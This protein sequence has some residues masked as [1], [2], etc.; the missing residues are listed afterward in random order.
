[1]WFTADNVGPAHPAVLEAVVRANQ[2]HADRYGADETM[3]RVTARLREVFE[4]P[5]AA[6]YLVATGTAANALALACLC[7]PWAT[8]YC[9]REAHVET[10]ECGAPGFYAGGAKLTLVDGDHGRID[11]GELARTLARAADGDV[12]HVQKGALTI[13]N[14][15]EAGTIYA[16]DEVARLAGIARAAGIPVHMD[17]ARFA[18]A[19]VALGCTPAELT[20]KAGID[21]LSF[22]GTKNGCL[23]VEAV[24]LFDPARAWE[25]ELRRKRGGHLVSKHRY[26]SAQMEAYLAD[27]LWLEL[28]SRANAS[29]ARL[30]QALAAMPGVRLRHPA[31]ANIV[32]ADWPR[33]GHRAAMAAGARYYLWEGAAL[34]GPG[35]EPLLARLVCGWDTAEADVARLLG[36]LRGE[37]VAQRA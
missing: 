31:E 9:H 32:F 25:F 23:G 14:A 27:G 24:I 15:T 20:W 17:G 21:A 7:P 1:M 12:H 16:P 10:D 34:E 11:A 28:A 3:G 30:A 35:D 22:G 36:V 8:I 33:A 19:L 29:A 5:E 13:T 6:V 18:N 2:G 4:A 26:L 37:E